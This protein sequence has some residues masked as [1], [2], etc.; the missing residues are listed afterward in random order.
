MKSKLFGLLLFLFFYL[1]SY[2]TSYYIT[3]NIDNLLL[4]LFVFD[5]IATTIIWILSLIIKNSSLYDAYWSI[6][7]M[8]L[9]TYLLL[10]KE[11]NIYHIIFLI[12]FFAWSLRLTINWIYTFKGIKWID[13]RY[14]MYKENNNFFVWH[15]INF[16]G[17]Q[18]MPTLFV[19]AGF[20][21]IY[22]ILNLD[23][24]T[25][26]LVGS[27]VIIIGVIIE[28]LADNKMH[29]F[30]KN[31][32]ENKTC[33][34]G[35]WKY[36]RHPNYLGEILIWIGVYLVLLFND[37]SKWYLCFGAIIMIILFNFISIPLMEKRQKTRR[38]DYGEYIKKT[39]RLLIL[40]NKK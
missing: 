39:S 4:R 20:M 3:M 26:S 19:F 9:T 24:N 12:A 5:I 8:I 36:S 27:F 18:M 32:K 6:T 7:P 29:F 16:F 11:L 22:Y 34:Q 37:T 13:W 33:D 35:L 40:P 10:N 2:I 15:I 25:F 30:L 31:T 17:I 21:P 28:F 1:I 23:I 38:N 14:Q